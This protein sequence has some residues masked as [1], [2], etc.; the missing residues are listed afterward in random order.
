M[1]PY[2]AKDLLGKI[3]LAPFTIIRRLTKYFLCV[4]NSVVISSKNN[5][6][7]LES[8]RFFLCLLRRFE[9]NKVRHVLQVIVDK[10]ESGEIPDAVAFASYP[11]PDIPS[12]EWSFTNRTL[13]FLGGT[14]D[15]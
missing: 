11:I 15:A 1:T 8:R 10:F 12:Y 6:A 2:T 13:M 5:K 3:D 14:G 4:L 7:L 9:M